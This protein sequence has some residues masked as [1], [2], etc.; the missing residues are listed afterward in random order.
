[1]NVPN[2]PG[3]EASLQDDVRT[4]ERLRAIAASPRG[5]GEIIE[6]FRP[7]L[8]RM[9]ELRLNP[10]LRGRVDPS[11]VLQEAFLEASRRLDGFLAHP[12]VPI[13]VWVRFLAGQKIGDLH[14]HHLGR[15]K[16]D[17]RR[18]A[19]PQWATPEASSVA[20]ADAFLHEGPSPSQIAMER[21]RGE[22]LRR[23]LDSLSDI[24]REVLAMRHF[25]GLQNQEV[26]EILEIGAPAASLRYARA[27]QRLGAVLRRPDA[28]DPSSNPQRPPGSQL[29][30]SGGP[31]VEPGTTT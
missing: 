10:R 16:R 23:A 30:E 2:S 8:R 29:S 3:R 1:M 6:E 19:G 26:A 22:Q 20:M 12:E 5:W 15:K 13:F 14:R 7:R 27:L 28:A 17:A 25:E 18:E 11:D 9:V 24:D 4:E 31:V 21:E